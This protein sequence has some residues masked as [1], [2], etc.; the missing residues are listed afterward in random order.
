[1]KTRIKVLVVMSAVLLSGISC[2]KNGKQLLSITTEV[3]NGKSPL[4]IGDTFTM[5]IDAFNSQMLYSITIDIEGLNY[6]KEIND[7][8]QKKWHYEEELFIDQIIVPGETDIIVTMKDKSQ[9]IKSTDSQIQL[10]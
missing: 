7:I 8:N 3:E 9:N 4:E 10:K 6:H 2:M 1:M 5:E